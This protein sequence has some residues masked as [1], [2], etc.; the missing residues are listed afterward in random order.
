MSKF[1]PRKWTEEELIE[2]VKTSSTLTEVVKKIGLRA[3]G[4]NYKTIK[5]HIERLNLDTSHFCPGA[6][7]IRKPR[8]LKEIL[9][10]DSQYPRQHLKKRLINSGLLKEECAFCGQSN[11]WLGKK[12][13][14]ILDHINGVYNDNRLS[15]LRLLCPNCNGY[16]FTYSLQ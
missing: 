5:C 13:S 4:G 1:R 2:A 10:T 8:D 11:I 12:I 15:N 9:T 3:A 14:L 6:K 16:L 7:R